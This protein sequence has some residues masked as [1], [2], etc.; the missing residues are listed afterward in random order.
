[1]ENASHKICGENQNTHILCTTTF[2]P[3][4]VPFMR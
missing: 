2:P 1:M 4:I 3:K